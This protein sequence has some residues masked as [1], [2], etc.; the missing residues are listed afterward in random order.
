MP[1]KK[2][3]RTFT[4]DLQEAISVA[5]SEIEELQ[6]EVQDWYDSLSGTNFE[7]SSKADMLSDAADTLSNVQ[8]GDI[9]IP[10]QYQNM[11]VTVSYPAGGYMSRARRLSEAIELLTQASE[12]IQH[13]IEEIDSANAELED[14]EEETDT[15][16]LQLII[17]DLE[18]V[19]GE[20]EGVEFPSMFS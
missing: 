20:I 6:Q 18:N 4:Y 16:E 12:V 14:G 1:K 8:L 5:S 11:K 2:A 13:R 17:D 3:M 19:V 10:I 9:E 7:S 15:S